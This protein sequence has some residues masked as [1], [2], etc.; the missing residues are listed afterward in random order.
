MVSNLKAH[1]I[2]NNWRK[3]KMTIDLMIKM[4]MIVTILLGFVF[5]F[6]YF[7]KGNRNKKRYKKTLAANV[8]TVVAGFLI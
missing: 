2:K 8:V 7:F 3:Y 1:G 5:P 4:T 6:T